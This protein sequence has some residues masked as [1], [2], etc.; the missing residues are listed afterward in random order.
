MLIDVGQG[1]YQWPPL[2]P[3]YSCRQVCPIGVEDHSH[4]DLT[5]SIA[6][7]D[8]CLQALQRAAG[9]VSGNVGDCNHMQEL[10]HL[11]GLWGLQAG[12]MATRYS[13]AASGQTYTR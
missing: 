1:N 2:N 12:I 11:A 6:S 9:T 10:L 4:K 7:L 3:A 13:R 8:V 5:V